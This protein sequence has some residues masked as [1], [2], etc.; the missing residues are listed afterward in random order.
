M[1]LTNE[2]PPA[3]GADGL[4][5][6]AFPGRNCTSKIPQ[7]AHVAQA[8][9]E[10]IRDDLAANISQLCLL[11]DVALAMLAASDNVG[12]LYG[13]RRMRGYW[14]A[15]SGSAAELGSCH[16]ELLSALRREE[17]AP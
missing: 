1:A 14:L 2:N 8:K 10:L 17:A 12:T 7:K 3:G 4:R 11:A 16:A 15:I 6:D 13:L 9:I 5:D